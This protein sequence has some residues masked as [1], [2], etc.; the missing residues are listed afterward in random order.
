MRKKYVADKERKR[1]LMEEIHTRKA[2]FLKEIKCVKQLAVA[3]AQACSSSSF[4]PCRI[5]GLI[6]W[7][8]VEFS[9]PEQDWLVYHLFGWLEITEVQLETFPGVNLSFSM[10]FEIILQFVCER[11]ERQRSQSGT[12]SVSVTNELLL[13]F[14]FYQEKY[15]RDQEKLQAEW[16]KAQQEIAKN[17]EQQQVK[18]K[19]FHG[20]IINLY[21]NSDSKSPFNHFKI[22]TIPVGSQIGIILWQFNPTKVTTTMGWHVLFIEGDTILPNCWKFGDKT[23]GSPLLQFLF[24]LIITV[25]T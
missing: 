4:S 5:H 16:Q 25:I 17:T 3:A 7:C 15:K 18:K 10:F 11:G 9:S 1:T 21:S 23:W 8:P 19:V 2:Y 14:I 13:H 12:Y 22:Q 24:G 6:L 20:L